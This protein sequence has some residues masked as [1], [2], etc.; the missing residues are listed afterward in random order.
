MK[1]STD[2]ILVTHVGS[3]VRPPKVV[4][5]QRSRQPGQPFTQED[6]A[7]LKREVGDAVRM[8]AECG[9]DI[10]SDGEFSKSSF[11]G[12]VTDRLTGFEVRPG[13]R[14]RM[15]RSR[16][17]AR[18]P[19][20]YAEID[21]PLPSGAAGGGTGTTLAAGAAFGATV[22]T[23][24]IT[25]RGEAMVEADI[26]NFRSAL[27]GQDFAEAFI[28]AVG[29]GTIELQRDNEYYKT[30]EEY[31]FAIAEAMKTE[32]K[33]IVDAGFILQIDDPRLVTEFDSLDPAP[34]PAE[35]AKFA[36]L[37]IEALN[38]AL[39]GLPEDRIRYHMC[40][41]SWHGPHTTDAELKDIAEV[42]LQVRAGGF[43][44]EAANPRHAHEYHVWEKI[45]FPE[46]KLLIPGVIAHTTNCVEHPEL[47]AERIVNYAR[48]VGRENVLAGADCGFAQGAFTQRVH[49]TIV[50][51][52]FR[53]LA[54]GAR[55][56]SERLWGRAA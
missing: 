3:L 53:M 22:C 49:P 8:Q 21:M 1:R 45:K 52:K 48:I 35:Y 43:S 41:G 25:Y 47:V 6:L 13:H 20:A 29:P 18:F 40:W 10:P 2:R 42:I 12:Y 32:Y 9:I 51:E 34:T 50:W 5:M 7:T 26:A 33:L 11:S 54:Q 39:A 16:D 30:Q 24:P 27:Q 19:E 56:A 28:P 36:S 23:G 14:G 38:H 31:L 17:R 4:E 37:R 15:A 55:L 44:L 46:G